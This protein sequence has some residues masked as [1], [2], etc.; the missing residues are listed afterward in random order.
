MSFA[1]FDLQP[2]PEDNKIS[3]DKISTKERGIMKD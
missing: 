3:A 2:V 1:R